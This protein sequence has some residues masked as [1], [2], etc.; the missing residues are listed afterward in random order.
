MTCRERDD[1]IRQAT[2]KRR[3]ADEKRHDALAHRADIVLDVGPMHDPA[4]IGARYDLA[5]AARAHEDLEQRRTT[6]KVILVP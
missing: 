2:D 1:V 5:D 3:D 4:E 6:G